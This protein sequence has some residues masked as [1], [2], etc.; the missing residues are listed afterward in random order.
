MALKPEEHEGGYTNEEGNQQ[1]ETAAGKQGAREHRKA[2]G[3]A[4][5]ADE[6]RRTQT[7]QHQA[8]LE[9]SRRDR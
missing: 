8:A 7:R 1:E 5:E 6:E 3:N 9:T 2:R 4:Q